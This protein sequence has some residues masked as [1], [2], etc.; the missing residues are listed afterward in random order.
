MLDK[1]NNKSKISIRKGVNPPLKFKFFSSSAT[2]N[3]RKF[4][5]NNNNIFINFKDMNNSSL[6]L[7]NKE[8][9]T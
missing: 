1:N 7:K 3:Y 5:D 4:I 9:R 2:S 8:K 6:F